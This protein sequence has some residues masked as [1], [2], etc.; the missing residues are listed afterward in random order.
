MG[1]LSRAELAGENG[2]VD[3]TEGPLVPNFKAKYWQMEPRLKESESQYSDT[4]L[5]SWNGS[6]IVY[7]EITYIANISK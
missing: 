7:S 6:I 2:Q 3:G 5:D 4:Y 1:K